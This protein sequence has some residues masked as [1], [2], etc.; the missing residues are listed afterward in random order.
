MS[1]LKII[2]LVFEIAILILI[3][4]IS[5]FWKCYCLSQEWRYKNDTIWYVWV[6]NDDIKM[7]QFD[8]KWYLFEISQNYMVTC[9]SSQFVLNFCTQNDNFV[10]KNNIK[11]NWI[12]FNQTG[13]KLRLHY[14]NQDFVWKMRRNWYFVYKMISQIMTAHIQKTKFFIISV[15]KFKRYL[16]ENCHFH[17]LSYQIDIRL[18]LIM[19]YHF[20]S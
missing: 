20:L 1:I 8:T 19:S 11:Q 18:Y 15:P 17:I 6:R 14:V 12:F 2:V 7:I 5:D 10:L 3:I 4:I 16:S 9:F 13:T